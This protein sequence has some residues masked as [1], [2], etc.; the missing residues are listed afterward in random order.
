MSFGEN[1]WKL[2]LVEILG[3]KLEDLWNR[4]YCVGKKVRVN[5]TN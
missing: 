2:L 5:V 4:L 3:V 1:W